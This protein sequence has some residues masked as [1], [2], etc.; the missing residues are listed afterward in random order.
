MAQQGPVN[1]VNARRR[2]DRLEAQEGLESVKQVLCEP[3]RLRIVAALDGGAE[4]CV[5]ELA[6]AIERRVPATSQHLRVLRDLGI[7]ESSRQGSTVYYRLT[8][9]DAAEHVRAVLGALRHPEQ[10]A[11]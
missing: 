5:G 4:L 3:T 8:P 2:I 7:V 6:T 1:I 10:A 11:S 9:G